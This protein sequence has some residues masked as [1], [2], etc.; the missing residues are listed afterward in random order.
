MI[1]LPDSSAIE[2]YEYDAAKQHLIVRVKWG[3]EYR[4]DD[5]PQWCVDQFLKAKSKGHYFHH[6]IR[7]YFRDT[8]TPAQTP[9]D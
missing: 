9:D 8:S 5:V 1:E 7:K 4:F 6:M 2:A 3:K